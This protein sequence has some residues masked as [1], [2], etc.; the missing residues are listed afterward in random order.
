MSPRTIRTM[1]SQC[2]RGVTLV[3]LVVA[4]AIVG[5]SA[6]VV[7]MTWTWSDHGA[8]PSSAATDAIRDARRRAIA[9]GT[10]QRVRLRVREDGRLEPSDDPRADATVRFATAHPDGSVH[11]DP[12]F[13]FARLAGSMVPLG[14]ASP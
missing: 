5:I 8:Q 7:L 13:G 4:L 6:T 11:A 14:P 9:T 10:V 3:E 12:T 1:A 2:R